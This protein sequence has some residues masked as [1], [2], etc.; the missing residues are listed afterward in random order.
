MVRQKQH[1]KICRIFDF[2]LNIGIFLTLTLC[3]G[4]YRDY[5]YVQQEKV[6]RMFLASS[7]VGT[8]DPRQD[9][10]PQGYRLLIAWDV[11]KSFADREI[12]ILAEVRLMSGKLETQTI[13]L[14]RKRGYQALYFADEEI[15]TYR[16]RAIAAD[17]EIL[18][19]ETSFLD[20]VDRNRLKFD[21]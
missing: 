15:M 5:L 16:V 3:S 13:P 11:P 12:V 6:N 20:S 7:H 21:E 19:L 4:C 17:G 18:Y 14:L 2:F 9:D 1:M 10:P 8:P